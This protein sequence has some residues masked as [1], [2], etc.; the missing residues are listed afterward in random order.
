M[1]VPQ[2]LLQQLPAACGLARTSR[3]W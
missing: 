1:A 3:S 2:Q